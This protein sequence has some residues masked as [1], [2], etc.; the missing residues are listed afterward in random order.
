MNITLYTLQIA[1]KLWKCGYDEFRIEFVFFLFFYFW[2][3]GSTG[4]YHNMCRVLKVHI[5]I[6]HFFIHT[7]DYGILTCTNTPMWYFHVVQIWILPDFLWND[8]PYISHYSLTV[9]TFTTTTTPSSSS[10]L[11]K[12]FSLLVIQ[13]SLISFKIFCNINNCEYFLSIYLIPSKLEKN[14]VYYNIHHSN[15][16]I[17][18]V[19]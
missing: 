8:Y 1:I 15:I 17:N 4:I 5:T 19:S 3:L 12:I 11:I 6:M 10:L 18:Y 13:Y 9:T 16:N 14:S 2:F 7:I